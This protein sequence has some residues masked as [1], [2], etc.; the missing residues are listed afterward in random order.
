MKIKQVD[1]LLLNETKLD[2]GIPINNFLHPDY[3]LLRLD[4]PDSGGG[5]I[6]IYIKKAYKNLK[7]DYMDFETIHVK[8]LINGVC[9][10][11]IASYKSPS[12]DNL[13]YLSKLENL[14]LVI[15]RE[16]PIFI[17]GDLNMDLMNVE[18]GTDLRNFMINND[19]KNLVNGYTRINQIF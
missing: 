13:T 17:I 6:M 11:F 14:L 5:G 9:V 10:N 1:L 2:N 19:C 16:E 3:D 4:R 18:K 12:Y 15:D 8:T 7:V